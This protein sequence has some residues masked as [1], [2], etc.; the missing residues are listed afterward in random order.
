MTRT[1]SSRESA[2]ATT[3]AATSPK[4][5]PMTAPGRTPYDFIVSANATCIANRVGCT[6]SIPLG[7]SCAVMAAV[8]EKP[9]SAAISGSSAAMVAA[10]TGSFASR[11]APIVAHCE[12]WPE[13]THTGPRS[14]WPT[15]AWPGAS[16]VAA[17]RRPSASPARSVAMMAVRTR[18]CPRRRVRVYARSGS[19][20]SR[21]VTQSANRCAVRR[22]ASVELADS[23]N[24]SG[25]LDVAVSLWWGSGACSRMACTLVPDI[26]YDDTAA[27]R[28][29]AS[30]S[31]GQ[32]VISCGTN[33]AQSIRASSSGSRVWCTIGG[34]RPC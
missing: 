5:W 12:P 9:D 18:R 3:A 13:N 34:T 28:G 15:A 7:V 20:T 33:N 22:S 10:N 14:S 32:G 11:S 16:P 26:P 25:L 1:P 21:S 29:V 23:G 2:P 24:N 19:D 31:R 4:E 8:T 27:R 17:M 30:P 6:R